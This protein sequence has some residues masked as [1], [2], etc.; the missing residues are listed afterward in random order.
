MKARRRRTGDDDIQHGHQNKR[1]LYYISLS[2]FCLYYLVQAAL[3]IL[4]TKQLSKTS[5]NSV[6]VAKI[7]DRSFRE[8][9]TAEAGQVGSPFSTSGR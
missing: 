8:L 3:A 9:P 1:G 4:H 6:N 2:S 5:E 7:Q